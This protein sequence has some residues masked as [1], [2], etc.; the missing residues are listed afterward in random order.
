MIV[1]LHLTVGDDPH[2]V[3]LIQIRIPPTPAE[4][5]RLKSRRSYE[6]DSLDL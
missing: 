2:Q 5:D 4:L 3:H 1:N 6:R